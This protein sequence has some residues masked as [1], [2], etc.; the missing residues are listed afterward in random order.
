M[1]ALVTA[2][3]AAQPRVLALGALPGFRKT[4]FLDA[5]GAHVGRLVN[6]DLAESRVEPARAIIDA[7]LRDDPARAAAA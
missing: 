5:F 7:L 6:C 3:S 1:A 2:V 4:A